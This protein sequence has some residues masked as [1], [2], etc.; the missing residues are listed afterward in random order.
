MLQIKRHELARMIDHTLLR[1]YASE[2]DIRILCQ[3]AIEN[4]FYAVSVNPTWTKL[5]AQL[6]KDTPVKVDVCVGFP[7][8]ATTAHIKVAETAEAIKNGAQEID[9][10][11]NIGALKS[12]YTAYVEKEIAIVV[13]TAGDV[14]VKVILET[15]Y[16]SN[17]EKVAVCEMAI[18]TGASFVKTSTGYGSRGATV[19]DV[20]LMRKAVGNFLG[21]KAAGGIRTYG[22]AVAMIEAGANRIGTS[23]SLEILQD[24]PL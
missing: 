9:M 7:L 2:D 13:K 5:C 10:V 11:I 16:L 1:P 6:L 8:G 4:N 23:T 3:E 22:E 18:R 24:A 12:G 19:E 20:Q 14:P 15:S 17:D 21:V